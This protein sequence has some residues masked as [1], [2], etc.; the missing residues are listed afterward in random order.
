MKTESMTSSERLSTAMSHREPD[1]VPFLLPTV[2]QGAREFG[3]SIRD[4]FSR[5]DLVAEGQWR[6]RARYGHDALLGFMY[7]AVEA[8][9]WGG[10][11]IYREDGPPNAGQ[12]P[13]SGSA[14]IAR[15][16][17]P[18][19]RDTPCLQKVLRLIRLLKDRAGNEVPVFGSVISPFSLPVMQLGFENYLLLLHEQPERF[20]QLMRL[21]EAFCVEWANAQLEAGAGAIAY[22]DPV[23]SPTIIPRALY[24][25]TG[26]LIARRTLSKIKGAVATSFAS[27]R[28]LAILDDVVQTGTV[29]IGASFL[30]DLTAVKAAARGR[31]TVM[32]NLNAI[33][34]RHWTPAEAEI[35]VKEAIAKAG[36]GG[37]FVLTDNHGEIPWQVPDS[38]LLAIADAVR[39]WGRYPLDWI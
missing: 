30:E 37:G 14:D 38:V 23:S 29:G 27:G 3:L 32:G 31:L 20:E 17:P 18:R 1:R 11:V 39:R 35:R 19:V 8:E 36:P 22:A 9:A 33:E 28:C 26:F 6:L 4:Y 21:N 15:L 2:M 13:L 10:E 24:L 34:M 25:K 5:P 16:E 12:P 7:G